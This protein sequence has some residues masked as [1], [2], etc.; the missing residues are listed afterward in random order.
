MVG[1][2]SQNGEAGDV[3]QLCQTLLLLFGACQ[4][5]RGDQ[6]DSERTVVGQ[7]IQN[8]TEGTD[9]R[10][11]LQAVL[12]GAVVCLYQFHPDLLFGLDFRLKIDSCA[13]GVGVW[14]I[15]EGC[16]GK[17]A[18]AGDSDPDSLLDNVRL[19]LGR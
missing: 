18:R 13:A 7:V 10:S 5:Q 15:G 12:Q 1:F 8:V 17:S 4:I 16:Q 9:W 6:Q 3:Q 14:A 11:D 19:Q 2:R